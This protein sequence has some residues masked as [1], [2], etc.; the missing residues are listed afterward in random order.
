MN[1]Q[2]N[3]N[4]SALQNSETP[5]LQN[6]LTLNHPASPP[7]TG[8]LPVRLGPHPLTTSPEPWPEPVDGELLLDS[9]AAILRRFVVLP[10]W[11]AEAL[12]DRLLQAAHRITMKGPSMRRRQ[13]EPAANNA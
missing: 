6:S 3:I 5:R 13:P 10:K 11:A 2:T 8:S 4:P 9:L 1:N 7:L 12:L